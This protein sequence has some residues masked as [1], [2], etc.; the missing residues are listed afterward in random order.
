VFV[1]LVLSSIQI[2]GTGYLLR[3]GIFA[4][5]LVRDQGKLAADTNGLLGDG[6]V[7]AATG[8][9]GL[10]MAGCGRTVV[11]GGWSGVGAFVSGLTPALPISTAPNGSPV[12]GTSPGTRGAVVVP[13][14]APLPQITKFVPVSGSGVPWLSPPP[15]KAGA[16]GF[17]VPEHVAPDPKPPVALIDKGLVPGDRIS[18]APKGMPVGE[19]GEPGVIPTGDVPSIAGANSPAPLICE[20]AGSQENVIS[21][22][23]IIRCRIFSSKVACLRCLRCGCALS[24]PHPRIASIASAALPDRAIMPIRPEDEPTYAEYRP[25]GEAGR[26]L[27]LLSR[28]AIE[29]REPANGTWRISHAADP[30]GPMTY[31]GFGPGCLS[32]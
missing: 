26:S 21:S 18:V 22:T 15:S 12:R 10:A 32:M 11:T 14:L 13:P 29:D 4:T 8:C 31:A 25:E 16:V 2:S 24:P 9:D 23:V 3:N 5:G 20:N 17:P 28:A 27:L 30:D 19:T 1:A 6:N 7:L